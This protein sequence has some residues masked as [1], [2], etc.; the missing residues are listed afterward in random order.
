[1]TDEKDTKDPLADLI[2]R[3]L[4]APRNTPEQVEE[5]R[6]NR[7]ALRGTIRQWA[8]MKED[9]TIAMI[10]RRLCWMAH[11]PTAAHLPHL[12]MPTMRR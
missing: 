11:A 2:E 1:M 12:P 4:D 5:S 10:S 3:F 7:E 6:R 9:G 8:E